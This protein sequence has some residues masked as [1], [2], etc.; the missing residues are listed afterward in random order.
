MLVKGANLLEVNT[1]S[2]LMKANIHFL[3]LPEQ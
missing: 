2:S 1:D 3:N